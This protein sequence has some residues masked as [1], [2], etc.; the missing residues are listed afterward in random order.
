MTRHEPAPVHARRAEIA[1]STQAAR[2][3][4]SSAERLAGAEGRRPGRPASDPRDGRPARSRATG[5]PARPARRSRTGG[6]R[7]VARATPRVAALPHGRPRGAAPGRRPTG[8]GRAARWPRCHRSRTGR[9]RAGC[10]ELDVLDAR[11]QRA[12]GRGRRQD[13]ERRPDR[14]VADRVDLRRDAGR[15]RPGGEVRELVGWRDPDTAAAVRRQRL[16]RL[17]A[18]CPRAGAAVRDPIDPSAKHFCQPTR[19]R[20]VG[21][22]PRTSP[23]RRPPGDRGVQP[24]RCGRT[25][26]AGAGAGP[27]SARCA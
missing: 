2:S 10:D 23:L 14:R 3:A 15:R 25:R 5:R 4:R 9:R 8:G 26:G 24:R 6:W 13:V 7:P 11:H 18:R 16:V 12:R 21:S 27:V 20:P 1:G 17:R 19:A 22:A